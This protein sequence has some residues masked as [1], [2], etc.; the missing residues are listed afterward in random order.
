[1]IRL[2]F[3]L[4]L[5]MLV[6]INSHAQPE[7]T[8]V[9]CNSDSRYHVTKIRDYSFNELLNEG[10]STAARQ[11]DV[12]HMPVRQLKPIIKMHI[13]Q[14]HFILGKEE[15]SRAIFRTISFTYPS[16][17][18]KGEPVMLSGLITIPIL[19]GYRPQC[20]LIY[21]RLLAT[22]N[23]IAPS[24]SIPIEAVLAADNTVCVFPDY[25]GCGI[26]EGNPLPFTA[27]NYHA[28]CAAEC[29]IS[30]FEILQDNGIVLDTEFYTWNTGYS[31][32]GGYALATHKYIENSLSNSLKERINL[33]WSLCCDG[34]YTP[35]KL[36]ETVIHKGD[37]GS[38]PSI[39]LQSL[40]GLFSS[41]SEQLEGLSI[42]SF[43]SDNALNLGID[44]IL[45]TY[46]NGLWD[47]AY[48]L[49]KLDRSHNP[50]YYFCPMALDTASILYKKIIYVLSLDNCL[51][52]WQP[53]SCV[54]LSHSRTDKSIPFRL[55]RQAYNKLSDNDGC[56]FIHTPALDGS[57]LFCGFFY[58]FN[59][60]HFNEN[61]L[62]YKYT[63]I[64]DE[65]HKQ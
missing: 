60:L 41:H 57:H 30:A 8:I 32:A 56:C 21:H 63:N 46:D 24:N 48:R 45:H 1:M 50:A 2:V 64:H 33:R 43:L 40:R 42:S 34:I 62:Y 10:I 28:R 19:N 23:N 16:I 7:Q 17:S 4:T 36:Y 20:M 58:I 49:G 29:V 53:R 59:L 26:T 25:F 47:L 3:G 12:L 35:D 5:I 55:T 18:P 6:C 14:H 65:K 52:N 51:S 54:V 61:E 22:Y 38:T 11:L 15:R 44:S 39:F 37:M 31:Q 13:K 27:L 9:P